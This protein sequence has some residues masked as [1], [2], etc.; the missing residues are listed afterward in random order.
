MA[1]RFTSALQGAAQ[2]AGTGTAIGSP[3]LGTA[4][5]AGVGAL[6][7]LLTG[8]E[9][10]AERMQRER[11]EE[12]MR[13]QELGQLGMT[14]QEINVALGQ[15]QG[16]LSQQ[17][18]A[19]R[20]Q[21][22]AL[23]ATT[24]VGAGATMRAGQEE[25]SQ[26]R[27]EMA[28]AR[29]R[30]EEADIAQRRA[31]EQE[32]QALGQ[33]EQ[34]RAEQERAAM[35]QAVS[36]GTG[37]I[38]RAKELGFAQEEAR[39]RQDALARREEARIEAATKKALG[40]GEFDSTRQAFSGLA[41]GQPQPAAAP[42]AAPA[43]D[44]VGGLED[45]IAPDLLGVATAGRLAN[46]LPQGMGGLSPAALQ[47]LQQIQATEGPEAARNAMSRLILQGLAFGQRGL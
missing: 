43:V 1:N 3:G 29:Q 5:G 11:M 7:G 37:Q 18:Q 31:E 8:G 46:V 41:S 9:T 36:A 24:G 14:D 34:R 10:D 21:Q 13:R 19:Q 26:Q 6:T 27:R 2:G 44:G 25:A 39:R 33:L 47:Y 17:Q 35:L 23:L 40:G 30:V 45:L 32:L 15:A 16:A 28:E 42:A 12:L 22:A 4:V 20:A 38:Q